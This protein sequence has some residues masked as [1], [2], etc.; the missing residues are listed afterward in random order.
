MIFIF[1]PGFL[2]TIWL[3]S[4]GTISG[5]SRAPMAP[6]QVEL[7]PGDP[8]ENPIDRLVRAYWNRHKA[9][10]E[11][12]P[13]DDRTFARRTW[14]DLVGM[15]PPVK[16]MEAFVYDRAPDKR[17]R[18][19]DRLLSDKSAYAVHW[20]TFWSDMLRNAY[21]GTGYID[22]GRKQIP[23]G[24]TMLYIQICRTI[25]LSAS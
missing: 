16:E 20:M 17:A 15:L 2:L 21:Q 9:Q 7:P 25:N 18:L 3:P 23:S 5:Q 1:L 13:L 14:L 19:V 10:V 12:K 4:S 22:G 24:S 8:T 6:R 11:I